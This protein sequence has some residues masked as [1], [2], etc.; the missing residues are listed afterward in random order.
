LLVGDVYDANTWEDW[1]GAD[2]QHNHRHA[3]LTPQDPRRMV[4]PFCPTP[5]GLFTITA[6]AAISGFETVMSAPV[7]A[8]SDTL[9]RFYLQA[10]QFG[11]VP[12]G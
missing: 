6:A 2:R 7:G 5:G 4:S 10:G 11:V 8:I 12:L 3:Q 9:R 1:T